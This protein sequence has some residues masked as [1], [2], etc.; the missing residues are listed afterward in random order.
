MLSDY[1]IQFI[2]FFKLQDYEI[3]QLYGSKLGLIH[4]NTVIDRNIMMLSGIHLKKFNND[5]EFYD[6][7]RILSKKQDID[8]YPT[9][10]KIID[11]IK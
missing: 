1:I 9:F 11:V 4:W 10:L 6:Y 8:F 5:I 7:I 2:H 3:N